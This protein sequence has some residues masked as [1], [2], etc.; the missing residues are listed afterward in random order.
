MAAALACDTPAAPGIL[1]AAPRT[2]LRDDTMEAL[3]RYAPGARLDP[4]PGRNVPVHLARSRDLLDFEARTLLD[5]VAPESL[6]RIGD[7]PGDPRP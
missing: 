4:V 1:V 2:Y 6:I 3:A 5:D 7:Y